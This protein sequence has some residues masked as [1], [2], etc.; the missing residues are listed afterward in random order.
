MCVGKPCTLL[1]AGC[2]HYWEGAGMYLVSEGWWAEHPPKKNQDIAI[3]GPDPFWTGSCGSVVFLC[4]WR[5]L[6]PH[7]MQQAVL[8]CSSCFCACPLSESRLFAQG[9]SQLCRCNRS[10][11]MNE[12]FSCLGHFL[13]YIAESAAASLHAYKHV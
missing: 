11:T 3:L 5:S 4:A 13:V 7:S 8:P 9:M 2:H 1:L 10:A 6:L 12:S